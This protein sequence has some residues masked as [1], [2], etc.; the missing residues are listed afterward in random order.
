MSASA[1]A[2]PASSRQLA[3]IER[4]RDEIGPGT[5]VSPV[6]TEL[7]SA[8]ASHIIK[9]LIAQANGATG[10]GTRIKVNE[11]QLGMAMKEC[12]RKSVQLG[13]DVLAEHRSSYIKEVVELYWLFTEI[14]ER[15]ERGDIHERK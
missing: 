3:Y 7:T 11:P 1:V 2:K 4:L 10:V 6:N 9:D 15:V 14:A 12:Y 13:K 5:Q 8:E